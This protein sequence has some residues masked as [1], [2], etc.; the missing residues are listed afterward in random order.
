VDAGAVPPLVALL[1]CGPWSG[2]A[3]AAAEALSWIAEENSCEEAV[4]EDEV[5]RLYPGCKATVRAGA[6]PLLVEII[7]CGGGPVQVEST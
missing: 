3:E 6:V 1:R 7:R 4:E 5:G 2:A